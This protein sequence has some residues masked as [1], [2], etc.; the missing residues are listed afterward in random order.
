MV[1]S[2]GVIRKNEMSENQRSGFLSA[3][4]THALVEGNI[5]EDNYVAGVLIKEPSL[6]ELKKNKIQR[7]LY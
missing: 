2:K 4:H 3:S 7:N 1:N 5:I 6:P